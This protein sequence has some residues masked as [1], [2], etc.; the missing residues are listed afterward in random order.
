MVATR[1]DSALRRVAIVLSITW[2]GA[3]LAWLAYERI[4][5]IGDLS[6]PWNFYGEGAHGYF[7][8]VRTEGHTAFCKLHWVRFSA[9][10]LTPIAAIWAI[11][12]GL[13]PGFRW[14]L[15]PLK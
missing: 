7:L 4:A 12:G 15:R 10:L 6:G 11:L 8:Y 9:V 14:A 5:D 2:L 3:V 1:L 13:I